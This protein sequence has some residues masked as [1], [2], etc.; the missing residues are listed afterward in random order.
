MTFFLR[1][2]RPYL[3]LPGLIVSGLCAL[4][5]A[6]SEKYGTC[7]ARC[8]WYWGEIDASAQ[9]DDRVDTPGLRAGVQS[10]E[11]RGRRVRG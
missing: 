2:Y 10:L 8:Q 4:L 1:L 9:V 11:S 3:F 7:G 5:V 6:S